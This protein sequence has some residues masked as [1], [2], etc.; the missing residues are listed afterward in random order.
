MKIN[1]KTLLIASIYVLPAFSDPIQDCKDFGKFLQRSGFT[2]TS[3]QDC[4]D[5][6]ETNQ[7]QFNITC[8]DSHIKTIDL[9]IYT[10]QYF[11]SDTGSFPLLSELTELKIDGE[12]AFPNG[13]LPKRFFELPKLKKLNLYKTPKMPEKT[14]DINSSSPVEEIN[15]LVKFPYVL[16]TLKNLK[17]LSIKNNQIKGNL[18]SE[19]KEFKSLKQL[20]IQNNLFEGELIIPDSLT[21]LNIVGNKFTTYSTSN[22]NTALQ[23]VVANGVPLIDNTFINK[24]SGLSNMKKM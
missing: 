20:Y 12:T 16:K 21:D 19:I 24:L 1:I 7:Y 3:S 13:I 2:Y 15:G 14:S 4:C 5:I 17:T 22:K 6:I 18:T 8:T 10:K 11:F 23:E 9:E